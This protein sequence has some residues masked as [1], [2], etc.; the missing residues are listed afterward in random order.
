MKNKTKIALQITLII[1]V[2]AL[3]AEYVI[4]SFYYAEGFSYGTWINGIYC[5][6]K[7]VSQ[8]NEELLRNENYD[9]LTVTG[10]DGKTLHI[11]PLDIHLRLDYTRSLQFYMDRQVPFAWGINL[12]TK[13]STIMLP[14][15]IYNEDELAALIRDWTAPDME[16]DENSVRIETAEE[17]GYRLVN[18]LSDRPDPDSMIDYANAAIKQKQDVLDVADTPQCYEPVEPTPTQSAL[19]EV[20]EEIEELQDCGITYHVGEE[21]LPVDAE[22][23]ASWLVTEQ[24]QEKL[25]AVEETDPAVQEG[26]FLVNGEKTDFPEETQVIGGFVTDTEGHPIVSI[27][28]MRDFVSD[29]VEENGTAAQMR[30]YRATK[31]PEERKKMQIVIAGDESGIIIDEDKELD[32]LVSAFAE[33]RKEQHEPAYTAGTVVITGESIGSEYIEI[34]MGAQQLTYYK[35]D[36]IMQ[37]FPVVTGLM[38]RARKTPTGY[39]RIYNK[40][41]S[42]ILRGYDYATFVNYWLGVNRGIGIHDATWRSSF[43]GDIY[44]KNGSHGCVNSPKDEMEKLYKTVEVGV[45]VVMYY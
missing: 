16:M 41:R 15:V 7:S 4:L 28:K 2:I 43:G 6:G 20:A 9:G 36:Q 21:A 3:V 31:D 12:F 34:D 30:A 19:I 8:V 22:T 14:E 11:D 1:S 24:N 13:D 27:Q 45:P 29:L 23:V 39:Y 17:G 5:T 10:R 37:Q 18:E 42:T 25:Q 35:D 44:I 40:R 33:G 26:A 32:Y 38:T